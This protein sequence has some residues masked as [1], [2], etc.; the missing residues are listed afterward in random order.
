MLLSF[1]TRARAGSTCVNDMQCSATRNLLKISLRLRAE[2]ESCRSCMWACCRSCSKYLAG[3]RVH[4]TDTAQDRA[5]LNAAL[6]CE[7][8]DL[9]L[10]LRASTRIMGALQAVQQMCMPPHPKALLKG[11]AVACAQDDLWSECRAATRSMGALQATQQTRM[12]LNL[13]PTL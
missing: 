10:E 11:T 8:D 6:A 2:G 7:R 13:K 1:H 3:A 5:P 4:R 9:W 12:L